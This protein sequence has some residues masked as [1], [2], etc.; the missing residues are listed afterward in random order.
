MIVET[1]DVWRTFGGVAAVA[2]V[3]FT[4]E[5]DE[6]RCLIGSN[7]AGKST[8]F[9][10]LTGQLLPSKG[11][12]RLFGK[13]MHRPHP[14]GIARMGVGIKTQTPSLFEGLSVRE[15]LY[16]AARRHDARFADRNVDAMLDE[17]ELR[18]RA[19]EPVAELSHGERQWVELGMVM[20]ADPKLVLLDEPAAGMTQPEVERTARLIQRM[21]EGR[22]FIIVEH[23]MHFVRSIAE[24]VT[25]FHR[26][27]I[28]VEDTMEMIAR[29]TEVREAYLGQKYDG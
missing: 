10:L 1:K 13:T 7:G 6:L 4:L 24:Q 29:N 2:G 5:Q 12:V 18:P 22:S 27:R 23:D 14:F 28:L 9:K 11:E 19:S 3:N 16:L 8:F 21:R 15:N 25:V 26:G 20:I 17:I